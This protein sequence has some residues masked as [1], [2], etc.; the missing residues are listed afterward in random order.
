M[1]TRFWN[2]TV[3]E[4]WKSR[5]SEAV[6]LDISTE[7]VLGICWDR[8]ALKHGETMG[9][10]VFPAI[11]QREA[12]PP[13]ISLSTRDGDF[14]PGV[15]RNGF[16]PLLLVQLEAGARFSFKTLIDGPSS[17]GKLEW[18]DRSICILYAHDAAVDDAS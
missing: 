1:H 11:I 15:T 5:E 16:Q 4:V 3:M 17:F 14:H 2:G 18:D 9:I 7:L 8:Q 13:A 6:I 12:M 10:L